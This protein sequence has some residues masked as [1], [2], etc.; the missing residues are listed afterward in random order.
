MQQRSKS[1]LEKIRD[2]YKLVLCD[3]TVSSQKGKK[4]IRNDLKRVDAIGL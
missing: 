1:I 4:R 2:A 3:T